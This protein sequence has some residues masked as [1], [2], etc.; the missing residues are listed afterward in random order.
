M[1]QAA[2]KF[3]NRVSYRVL[4]LILTAAT[5]I[6]FRTRIVGRENIPPNG[7]IVVARHRSFWDIPLV[8]VAIHWNRQVTFV[9]RQTLNDDHPILRPV[10]AGF[11]ITVNRENFSLSDFK[12]VMKAIRANKLVAIFPEGTIQQTEK[13]FPGVIRFAEQTGKNFLPI[14]FKIR[15]G[16]YGPKYPFGFPAL[17]LVVG[18]PFSVR[19]LAFDLTGQESKQER[20]LQLSELLMRRIDNAEPN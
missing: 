13:V 15:K 3:L 6:L 2:S 12:L 10:L 11:S 1:K 16:Q 20:Y 7:A 9:A 17:T 18:R 5:K 19:D 4:A 14:R 8:A